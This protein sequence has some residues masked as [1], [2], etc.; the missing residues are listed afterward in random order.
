M[1]IKELP[2]LGDPRFVHDE[3]TFY[4]WCAAAQAGV[5]EVGPHLNLWWMWTVA[6]AE[7]CIQIHNRRIT[8]H[9]CGAEALESLAAS[10]VPA[11]YMQNDNCMRPKMLKVLPVFIQEWVKFRTL[12]GEQYL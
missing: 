4:S 9:T 3:N 5:R 6:E 1:D 2:V 10:S 12:E 8:G 11:R 7:R